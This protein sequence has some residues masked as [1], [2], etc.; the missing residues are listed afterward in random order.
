[1]I[2]SYIFW[3]ENNSYIG[4]AYF[5]FKSAHIFFW[6]KITSETVSEVVLHSWLNWQIFLFS[7]LSSLIFK[8]KYYL[9]WF[10]ESLDSWP[11]LLHWASSIVTGFGIHYSKKNMLA[12]SS[13]SKFLKLVAAPAKWNILHLISLIPTYLLPFLWLDGEPK[14]QLPLHSLRKY[15][16]DQRSM[17]KQIMLKGCL[18]SSFEAGF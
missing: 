17:N 3:C 14:L 6:V 15:Y 8:L 1:M 7:F 12:Y 2:I 5:G 18:F 16:F 11:E 10:F 13:Y 9:I 4:Y